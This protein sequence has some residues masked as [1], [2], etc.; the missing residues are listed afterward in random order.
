MMTRRRMGLLGSRFQVHVDDHADRLFPG[1]NAAVGKVNFLGSVVGVLFVEFVG[2]AFGTDSLAGN[3]FFIDVEHVVFLAA[4]RRFGRGARFRIA[5]AAAASAASPTP[6]TTTGFAVVAALRVG[7]IAFAAVGDRFR[8]V[9][10]AVA[11]VVEVALECI[12]AAFLIGRRS[13]LV[14]RAARLRFTITIAVP[15]AAATAAAATTPAP[16][17]AILAFRT[18]FRSVFSTIGRRRL[19]CNFDARPEPAAGFAAPRIST[20]RT[21]FVAAVSRRLFAAPFRMRFCPRRLGKPRFGRSR[22][23]HSRLGRR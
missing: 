5:I 21:S 17:L 20:L 22:F 14:R 3:A 15:A 9:A 18:R 16:R 11:A 4:R 10:I 1:G 6:A 23:G 7:T 19:A 13:R 8:V 2:Q 12:D